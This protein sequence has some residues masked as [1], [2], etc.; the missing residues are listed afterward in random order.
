MSAAVLGALAFALLLVNLGTALKTLKLSERSMAAIDDLTR[1]VAETKTVMQSAAVLLKGLK[2]RLDQ[3]G[4]DPVKL[5]ALSKDLDDSQAELPA[6]G[7]PTPP[8]P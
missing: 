5:A 8:T 6:D 2:D 4:T 7:E 3:A 1:E